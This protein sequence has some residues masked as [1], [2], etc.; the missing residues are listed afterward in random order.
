MSYVEDASRRIDGGSH[1]LPTA[2]FRV[3]YLDLLRSAQE[4]KPEITVTQAWELA[5][6][7]VREYHPAFEPDPKWRVA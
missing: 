5:V 4:S 2:T 6:R 7:A 1:D 3:A